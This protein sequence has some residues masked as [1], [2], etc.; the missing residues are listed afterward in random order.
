MDIC[1]VGKRLHTKACLPSSG[2]ILCERWHCVSFRHF[3]DNAPLVGGSRSGEEICDFVF[4]NW[5]ASGHGPESAGP[6]R[7]SFHVSGSVIFVEARCMQECTSEDFHFCDGCV[8]SSV[9][10]CA[11]RCT[12]FLKFSVPPS[13]NGGRKI[14]TWVCPF[15]TWGNRFTLGLRACER[16]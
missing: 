13:R 14:A 4:Y 15:S 6:G 16:V 1:Q 3:D 9:S 11:T 2:R 7:V 5:T 8:N 10:H 12:N